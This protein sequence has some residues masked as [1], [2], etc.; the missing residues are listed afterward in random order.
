MSLDIHVFGPGFGETIILTWTG[1]DGKRC[2]AVIDA[3]SPGEGDWLASRLRELQVSEV[4]FAMATHPHLDH[5]RGLASGLRRAG[6]PILRGGYWPP[7]VP[8]FWIEYFD[9]LAA[10]DGGILASTAKA[11]RDWF[12]LLGSLSCENGVP[13]GSLDGSPFKAAFPAI[14]GRDAEILVFR[15]SPWLEAM[16]NYGRRV[17]ATV[18]E[19]GP[20]LYSHGEVNLVSHGLLLRYGQAEIVLGGDVEKENWDLLFGKKPGN[21]IRPSFVKVSHHGSQTGANC[22]L[23]PA[24]AGFSGTRVEGAIA[25]VTPWRLGA[26]RLPDPD[27]SMLDRIR[28]AGFHVCQTGYSPRRGRHL[29]SHVSARVEADGRVSLLGYYKASVPEELRAGVPEGRNAGL[30]RT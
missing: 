8:G 23:W 11:V 14:S 18:K 10:Q 4:T 16:G 9:R 26:R 27:G 29:D 22:D 21:P 1:A 19:S 17:M 24:G 2:G 28:A 6:L 5:V 12:E 25:V 7:I 15:L 3:C 13:V 20:I 30:L